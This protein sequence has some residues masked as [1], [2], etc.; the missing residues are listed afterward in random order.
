MGAR[1]F[2]NLSKPEQQQEQYESLLRELH[3]APA[4]K[5]PP[6]GKNPFDKLP[7]GA[8]TSPG[9]ASFV[10]LSKVTSIGKS[11]TDVYASA[12]EIARQSDMIAW[13][14]TV[15]EVRSSLSNVLQDWRER[16]KLDEI[17]K[18]EDLPQV[19]DEAVDLYAPL[20]VIALAGIQS[21]REKFRDQRAM[22]DELSDLSSW[23]RSGSTT[24]IDI[25]YGMIFAFQAM[26]GAAFLDTDQIDLAIQLAQTR[27]PYWSQ[28]QSSPL[29]DSP[30]LLGWPDSLGGTCTIAWDFI[31]TAAQRWPWL[32]TVF[33]VEEDY[34]VA[35]SA[36]YMALHVHELAAT[37]KAGNA[38]TLLPKDVHVT[39]SVPL[40]FLHNTDSIPQK[41]YRLLL[42]NNVNL[43]W[44]SVGVTIEDM[45]KYWP[46]WMRHTGAWL[47]NVY[48]F[49]RLSP[50]V[51]EHLLEEYETR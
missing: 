6:I 38:D 39:L 16:R 10:P 44:E 50:I 49:W 5:K 47:T 31:I 22:I 11:T 18:K 15:K 19:M 40:C 20:F 42:R 2:V 41:A 17:R 7:S 27:I 37:I 12:L 46:T 8:E 33:G 30:H 24:I 43:L 23:K 26:C 29:I 3:K 9:F 48:T 45:K 21:G 13:R 28:S 14:R 4:I 1:F 32:A 35:L 34:R 25:P 51:H 36:Y